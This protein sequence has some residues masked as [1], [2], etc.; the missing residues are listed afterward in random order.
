MKTTTALAL[1]ILAT[2]CWNPFAVA[3][4]PTLEIRAYEGE[5]LVTA[6]R[7]DTTRVLVRQRFDD[8]RGFAGL[9]IVIDHAG[10]PR[11]TYTASDLGN[12]KP[13]F[14]VPRHGTISVVARIVQDGRAVAEVSGEWWLDS[15]T[16]WAVEVDRAPFPLG[17]GVTDLDNP[18]C[19]W[20]ACQ[21][22]WGAPIAEDDANY[23]GEAL[24]ITI[25]GYDPD[26]CVDVC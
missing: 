19:R 23:A 7:N 18:A 15:D 1:A 26:G 16:Q 5:H 13:K 3:P 2:G 8:P 17:N 4:D 6:R 14:K 20:F 25:F 22:V 9:E 12:P 21:H 10:M 24:W 11:R